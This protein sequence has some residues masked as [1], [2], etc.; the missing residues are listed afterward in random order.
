MLLF[1]MPAQAFP[2]VPE[3]FREAWL[4]LLHYRSEDGGWMSEV[5]DPAFF[6]DIGGRRNPEHEWIAAR[7]AFLAPA[8]KRLFGQHPRCRF[9]ARFALMKKAL[10]WSEDDVG[11]IDCPEVTAHYKRLNAKSLSVVFVSH[12]LN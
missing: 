1:G 5:E 9:P 7:E 10:D 11:H 2:Q 3:D 6:V 4:A 8:D 12:Y